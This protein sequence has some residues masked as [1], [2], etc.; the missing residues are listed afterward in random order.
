MKTEANIVHPLPSWGPVASHSQ[1]LTQ[2]HVESV[3]QPSHVCQPRALELWRV[4][5]FL[6]LPLFPGTHC[7]TLEYIAMFAKS[8]YEQVLF[9]KQKERTVHILVKHTHKNTHIHTKINHIT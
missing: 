9:T 3:Q 1:I 5:G 8:M 7:P 2:G 4:T 6:P